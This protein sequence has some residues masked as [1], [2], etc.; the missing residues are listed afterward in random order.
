MRSYAIERERGAQTFKAAD[1]DLK[2]FPVRVL[3]VHVMRQ[4]API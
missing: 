4:S 2:S 1:S 3:R